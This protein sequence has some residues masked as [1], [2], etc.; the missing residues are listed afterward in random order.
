MNNKLNTVFW[1]ITAC[2][3]VPDEKPEWLTIFGMIVITAS[4][5][6]FYKSIKKVPLE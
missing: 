6:M 5:I 2:L 1:A 3:L 4:L